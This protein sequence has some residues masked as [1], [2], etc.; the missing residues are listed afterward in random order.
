MARPK[1]AA[2]LL[3]A[4]ER[5]ENA[6]WDLLAEYPY[7]K[8]TISMLS[9]EA[10]VNHNTV[11]YYYENID[12]LAEKLFKK[13]LATDILTQIFSNLGSH[14]LNSSL[15]LKEPLP[16]LRWKR[17]VLFA[18]SDSAFL[19]D[20]FKTAIMDAWLNAANINKELLSAEDSIELDFI[21]SGLSSIL[22]NR[23]HDNPN[24]LATIL[25]RELGAG[26]TATFQRIIR[27][28]N[29]NGADALTENPHFQG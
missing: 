21:F 12:D 24:M 8:I 16:V 9:K 28:Q 7:S 29:Q 13:N 26:I 27:T 15:L 14:N 23:A 3:A 11:Y 20:I 1:K 19:T 10:K 25:D 22:G 5:I 6:F 4:S 2:D 18:R 17:A